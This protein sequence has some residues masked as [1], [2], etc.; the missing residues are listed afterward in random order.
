[1]LASGME[2]PTLPTTGMRGG[3]GRTLLTA[4]LVLAIV[5]LSATSWYA[6]VRERRDIQREVTAKL[7]SVAEVIG[8]HVRQW[9]ERH[10]A[11]LAFLAALPDLEESLRASSQADIEEANAARAALR[12]RA[13]AILDQ[14]PA[15]RRVDILDNA[16]IVL[17]STD[18]QAEDRPVE[19]IPELG[20]GDSAL[21]FITLDPDSD[22]GL[23]I[24]QRITSQNG[25]PLGHAVGWLN[26]SEL[27]DRLENIHGLGQTGEIY[28]VD[29]EGMALPHGKVETSSGI[30]AALAGEN[31]EGLQHN[32][33][34]VPVIGVYRWMPDLGLAL[35]AEQSQEE[36][37]AATY[38]VTAAIVGVALVV[39]LATAV[40][41][42]LVTR[43]I[44]RP[45]VQLTESAL[46]IAGGD[47]EQHVPVSSRDEIGILAYVFNRMVTELKAL[48]D[49][50][51]GKVAQ[52]TALLQRANYQIQR[53]AIQMQASLE[54]SQAVTSILD[55][56]QLLEQLVEVVRN[57]FVYSYAAVYTADETGQYLVLRASA[58]EANPFHGQRVPTDAPTTVG[59]AFQTREAATESCPIP[60]AASPDPY[61]SYRRSELVLPLCLGER[62]L[63][64]LD[65]QST[66]EDGFD[67]DDISVL[68]NVAS[69][70]TIALENA[71][72][73]AVEREAVK[74]LRELDRSKRRFLANMSHELRTPLTNIIGFSHLLLKGISGPLSEQQRSDIQLIYQDGQ[75]LL[76][77]INDLLDISQIEA[78]LMELE[79]QEVPL[80]DLIHSVMATASALVRDK[81]IELRQEIAPNLPMVQADVARIR[82][83]LLQLLANAAKF[84]TQGHIT[85]RAW[86][87]DGHVLVSVT[88][89]GMGIPPEDHARIFEQFEQGQT[90]NGR[91][92]GAGLGLALSKEFVEMH[93]GRIWVE[94]EVGKGSTFTFS[95][96]VRH[97]PGE[98]DE[99]KRA[100]AS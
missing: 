8:M 98:S 20:A 58:G 37:F 35:V 88:D 72:A 33:A 42:A 47:L 44:T 94:S 61:A 85:V 39:A 6:A 32:Y 49:D 15:F 2:R 5:P 36:A 86:P 63:G 1:M 45:V 76:G 40:I 56:D 18:P 46:R 7:S 53:R 77:L 91:R 10:G 26:L 38:A 95:L 13:Q 29:P 79:F 99:R 74:Q 70:I 11:A 80:A 43:Q 55:P 9:A 19:P 25:E 75:H 64:V 65:V 54:V 28:L 100:Q 27:A 51:E 60:F 66:D 83:V 67:Q 96:P 78:G 73:Y 24:V 41:A 50:L 3:L 71:R 4:F 59:R 82:Q 12:A 69:Q 31:Q 81:A 21:R 48:Y 89:T 84:T 17:I 93:G 23:V 87:E 16:G 14:D 30:A 57:R 34:D 52:R 68:K 90:G 92:N 62:T 22:V 97:N